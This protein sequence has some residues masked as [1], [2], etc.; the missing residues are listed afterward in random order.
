MTL[1]DL[2][3]KKSINFTEIGIDDFVGTTAKGTSFH[4][5]RTG[6]AGMQVALSIGNKFITHCKWQTAFKE[7]RTK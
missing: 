5:Y 2:L 6:G 4:L 3:I 7:I 1:K